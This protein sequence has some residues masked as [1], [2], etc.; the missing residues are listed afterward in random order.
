MIERDI[1]EHKDFNN[2]DSLRARAIEVCLNISDIQKLDPRPDRFL[3]EDIINRN[4]RYEQEALYRN[5][6]AYHLQATRGNPLRYCD[7]ENLISLGF[8]RDGQPAVAIGPIG[9]AAAAP[10]T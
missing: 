10:R 2:A 8:G 1:P 9:P 3:Y 7:G 6:Y 4:M 5:S